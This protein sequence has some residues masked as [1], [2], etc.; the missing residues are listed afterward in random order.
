MLERFTWFKQS[1]FSWKGEE[2][3]L[4]IDPWGVTEGSPPADLLFLTHAHF[5]HFSPEDIERVRKSGTRIFAPTDVAAEIGG[6]V[7]A[8]S[9]GDSFEASGVKVQTVPAYNTRE[10]RLDFHPMANGWVGYVLELAGAT[11]YHAGDTD[12]LAELEAIE[13]D[14][15]FVPIG[16]TYTMDHTEAAGLVKAMVPKLAVPMHFAHVVGDPGDASAFREEAAP[17]PVEIM[18]P[19]VPFGSG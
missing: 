6:D 11:V 12:H 16:G 5:D 3:V 8:V 9:P 7:T 18:T 15:A 2:L 19:Q 13:A 17:I 1:A 14:L 10:D 4:Y